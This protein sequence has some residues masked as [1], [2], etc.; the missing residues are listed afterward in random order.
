MIPPLGGS[1]L[2]Y[3]ELMSRMSTEMK[4]KINVIVSGCHF[5]NIDR[6]K[7]NILWQQ[8]SYDQE[9]VKNISNPEF[10]KQIDAFVFVSHW[11]YE[12]FKKL[13]DVP[14]HKSIV[15]HNATKTFPIKSKPKTSKL[16]IIYTSM[17][18]RG[19]EIL[20]DVVQQIERD[21]IEL[22]VYSSSIIYGTDYDNAN[23]NIFK[24]IFDHA[25][26][27]PNVFTKGYATN[28]EIRIALE[29]SHIML[30][31]CIFE[32]TSCMS[33]I[34]A[35]SAGCKV[36]CN[37]LGALPETCGTWADI[38][39]YDIDKQ[40]AIKRFKKLL[41]QTIDNYWSE[42]T[43]NKLA[44]QVQYYKKYWSWDTRIIQWNKL[45]NRVMEIKYGRN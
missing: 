45:F 21:D 4:D 11:Q 25:R 33:V 23:K 24:P 20:L 9:N 15:I 5:Q 19:L 36:A 2:A 6:N 30:Y 43:Q 1:E 26:M 18:Y 17:P 27:I 41:N 34:E 40:I 8:L 31:P 13:F 44:D 37:N 22:D 7:I 39:T 32:E 38:I 16:K 10:V 35:L 14:S 29:S 3:Q 42:E 12:K 28:D